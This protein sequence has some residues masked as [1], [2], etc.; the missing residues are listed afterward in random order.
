MQFLDDKA[1]ADRPLGCIG[2]PFAWQEA[3]LTFAL[4]LQFF[5]FKAS[6]PSYILKVKQTLTIKPQD[7]KMRATMRNESLLENLGQVSGSATARVPDAT[8]ADGSKQQKSVPAAGAHGPT[9]HIFYGSNTGTCESLAS[10]LATSAQARGYQA[11]VDVLDKATNAVSDTEPTIIISAS[12][13]GEPPDNAAQFVPWLKAAPASSLARA[14]Y[15]VFGV[16]NRDWVSTYQKIPKLVDAELAEKGATR[17]VERGLVDV[18]DGEIFN[19]FDRWVDDQLWP[20]VEKAFGVG[21]EVTTASTPGLSVKV[22][23]DARTIR[24]RQDVQ[25]ALV[26]ESRVLTAAGKPAKRHLQLKLPT[27]MKYKAGDYLAVL[28]INP[29]QSIRR[30]MARFQLTWDASLTIEEGSQTTIPTGRPISASDVFSSY[31]ELG[32]PA[33]V[34][35][36]AELATLVDDEQSR[37]ELEECSGPQYKE[38]IQVKNVSLLD[39]LERYPSATYTLGQFLEAVPSMRTRQYSI[40]SSPLA[41]PA[42][43]SLTYSVLNAP[44]RSASADTMPR[45]LGVA[46]NY[47]AETTKGDQVQISL[48]PSHAGFR[49]PADDQAPIMMACAGTGLAPFRAFVQERAVKAAAGIA[50]G[51]ALLFYGCNAPDDDD[52]YRDEF[53]AWARAGVVDV[54][55]AYTFAPAASAGC[56]FVQHRV[57]HDRAELVELFKADARMYIC[58][59]G[60]VGTAIMDTA[61]RIYREHKQCDEAEAEAWFHG[62]RG[63]RYWADIFS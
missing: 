33:T 34:K 50:L 21:A 11:K 24:L 55:R 46:S 32:Q 22:E 47:L 30:A 16:G 28:P 27:G 23:K 2:R 57:W 10:S 58:G 49:L 60:V 62:L 48:R 4:L 41:E 6:D 52:M 3:L 20:A 5:D 38:L 7:F 31:V 13:E 26:V 61:Q 35:Q 43:A 19:V 8:P 59:A 45:F 54:R 17:L 40:S 25:T 63:E 44:A 36:I 37:R 1:N 18:A 56:R 15:A 12:Y 9:M 51:P 29:T 39:L 53:D 14:K 42:M